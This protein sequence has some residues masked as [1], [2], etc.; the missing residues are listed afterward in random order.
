MRNHEWYIARIMHDDLC[1]FEC[2][3]CKA[4]VYSFAV[5]SSDGDF[6]ILYGLKDTAGFRSCSADCD[7][8]SIENLL[9]E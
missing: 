3:I 5:P 9:Q 8:M 6:T 7:A 4:T 2:T 1:R